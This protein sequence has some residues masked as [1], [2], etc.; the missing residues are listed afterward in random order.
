M[1]EGRF[2]VAFFILVGAIS[3]KLL[4]LVGPRE[5]LHKIPNRKKAIAKR[6]DFRDTFSNTF[7]SYALAQT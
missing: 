7:I 6:I 2:R 5:A 3:V 1:H 4:P